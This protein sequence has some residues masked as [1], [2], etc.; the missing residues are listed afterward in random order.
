VEHLYRWSNW[1]ITQKSDEFTKKD[2][3]TIEFSAT[4]PPDGEKVITY[5]VKYEWR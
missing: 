1:S 4:L 3:Q 2:A 5:R